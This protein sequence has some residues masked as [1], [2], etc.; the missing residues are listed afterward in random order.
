MA[1]IAAQGNV[2]R[3]MWKFHIPPFPT[4]HPHVLPISRHF[5]C[6]GEDVRSVRKHATSFDWHEHFTLAV[7]RGHMHLPEYKVAN[8][9]SHA[10]RLP[11]M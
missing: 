6:R 10:L 11:C 1:I 3:V 7:C 4:L 5:Q 2:T 9:F 8:I